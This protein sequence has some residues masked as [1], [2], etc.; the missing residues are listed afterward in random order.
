MLAFTE[1]TL[2]A[3]PASVVTVE[4]LNDSPLEHNIAFYDG[5]DTDAPLIAETDEEAG[6]GNLQTTTFT[7]P[8][9]PG[10]YFFQCDLHPVQMQGTLEIA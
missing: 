4:Y 10:T 1:S 7:T 8:A 3:P 9:E 2:A 5:A 6:P